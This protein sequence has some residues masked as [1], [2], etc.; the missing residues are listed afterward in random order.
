MHMHMHTPTVETGWCLGNVIIAQVKT[1]GIIQI[2]IE[3]QEVKFWRLSCALT[4]FY[5]ESCIH[6]YTQCENQ[7]MRDRAY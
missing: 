5:V 1:E 2:D 4:Q 7:C 6:W 3:F